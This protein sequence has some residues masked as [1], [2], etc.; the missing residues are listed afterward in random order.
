MPKNPRNKTRIARA[1]CLLQS[2]AL[3]LW[4]A[5][6]FA[7]GYHFGTQSVSAQGVAISN[8]AQ[9]ADAT[10]IFYN[11][12][13]LTLL[14]GDQIALPL[15]TVDT[16]IE[17]D[18]VQAVNAQRATI[19][20]PSGDGPATT[21]VV[22]HLYWAHQFNER[23]YGGVGIFVP[24]GDK[25]HYDADW[26]GRYNGIELSLKTITFNPQ[27][28]YEVNEHFAFGL[29]VSAQYMDAKFRKAADFGTLAATN[30][31]EFAQELAAQHVVLTQTQLQNAARAMS[32]NPAYDGV[33]SYAGDDWAFGFNVG[34]L[35]R[36]DDTLRFGVAYRS[37]IK[38]ELKGD[39]NWSRP[40]SF[41]NDAFATVPM[42]GSTVNVSWNTAIQEGL[43]A[44]GFVNGDGDVAVDTPDSAALNVFKKIGPIA[45]TAD[46]THTWHDKF[47]E[48]RL[49]FATALPDAVID[50]H[51]HATDR[52][53]VGV[54]YSFEQLPL[55]LRAGVAFDESPA[56]D[57]SK[58]IANLPDNDRTWY[59]IG[60]GYSFANGV[61]LDAAYTYVDIKDARMNNTE[62][63]LPACTGSGTTTQAD[64]SSYA[65]VFG[66]QVG[67]TFR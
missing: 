20:G 50:Q 55:Q 32:S 36:V 52:Y 19:F 45:V 39:A 35:W 10:V 24:F 66:L 61:V 59:S 67:Y 58:R 38:H 13:G 62:C 57:S 34:L 53:S 41:R 65:N 11:P 33:L 43:D 4:P 47:D 14:E 25:T 30:L 49:E 23:L 27:L 15:V 16:H 31:P 9:G 29:G 40:A 21:V 51:W 5:Q 48:L 60:A 44:Q 56:P 42:V 3:V 63:V 37:S 12:A 17:A 8:A 26:P 2:G 54:T 18:D 22:P 6:S 64:F 1:W 46:W 28:A 7:S